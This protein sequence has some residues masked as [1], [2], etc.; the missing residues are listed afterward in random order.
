MPN[1][2]N[3]G[4][5]PARARDASQRPGTFQKGH[6]KFGGRKK[7]TPNVVT[8]DLKIAIIEAAERLGSDGK[9]KDG[10]VG[11]LMA[12]AA[13]DPRTFG[14][15]LRALLPLQIAPK[16]DDPITFRSPEEL[17]E[18][19]I[20]QGCPPSFLTLPVPRFV[21]EDEVL[22]DAEEDQAEIRREAEERRMRNMGER[23]KPGREN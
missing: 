3:R 18:K 2:L 8:K 11:Y 20:K 16:Y 9:G 1:P 17:R 7:G 22:R 21:T 6:R 10:L 23:G 19:L 5:T 12:L 4:T 15:L 14:A 13:V